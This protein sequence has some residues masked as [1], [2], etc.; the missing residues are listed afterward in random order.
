[1]V[2]VRKRNNLTTHGFHTSVFFTPILPGLDTRDK[3]EDRNRSL[4]RCG[5]RFGVVTG[6][7]V[8]DVGNLEP[9]LSA[10]EYRPGDY[11]TVH[12]DLHQHAGGGRRLAV[13]TQMSTPDWYV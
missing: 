12:N 6:G 8:G 7:G 2:R 5:M 1:M 4:K 9:I 3:R 13:V 10:T 11:L